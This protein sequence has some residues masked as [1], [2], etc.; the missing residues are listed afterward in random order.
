ML[1]LGLKIPRATNRPMSSST[2]TSS[3]AATSSE[4]LSIAPAKTH[5]CRLKK[6]RALRGL[7]ITREKGTDFEPG[8][9]YG[10]RSRSSSTEFLADHIA[11]TPPLATRLHFAARR[12]VLPFV[13]PNL[14]P[15]SIRSR[16]TV[17]FRKQWSWGLFF[18]PL[19]NI[20]ILL[21]AIH[22]RD[23]DSLKGLVRKVTIPRFRFPRQ[24]QRGP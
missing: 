4:T 15:L 3:P 14:R 13:L 21:V 22:A 2:M 5:G 12:S 6:G 24:P 9:E 1:L 17:R 10:F 11:K 7:R 19:R 18:V 20:S 8:M 23:L 16:A